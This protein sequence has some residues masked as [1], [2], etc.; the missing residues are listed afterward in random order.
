MLRLSSLAGAN[1]IWEIIYAMSYIMHTQSCAFRHFA[2]MRFYCCDDAHAFQPSLLSRH[3]AKS[4]RQAFFAELLSNTAFLFYI[5]SLLISAFIASFAHDRCH[6]PLYRCHYFLF[7]FSLGRRKAAFRCRRL[8]AI[9]A[10]AIC[11]AFRF[12]FMPLRHIYLIKKDEELF[13]LRQPFRLPT[14]AFRLSATA[15]LSRPCLAWDGRL[16]YLYTIEW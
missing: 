6:M 9:A 7:H 3:F 11:F 14:L 2:I 1:T 13:C 16:L 10:R 5:L 4:F 15:C 8:H 12:Y